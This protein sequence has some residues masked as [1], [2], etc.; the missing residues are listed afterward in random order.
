VNLVNR[1]VTYR[2]TKVQLLQTHSRI[3]HV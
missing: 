1:V 2:G 3:V